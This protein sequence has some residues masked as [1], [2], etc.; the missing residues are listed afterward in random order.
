M[1]LGTSFLSHHMDI[2]GSTGD[3]TLPSY[4]LYEVDFESLSMEHELGQGA[5]G[6]VMKATLSCAPEGL[7][8]TRVPITVAAKM[9]K[10][11]PKVMQCCVAFKLDHRYLLQ[12]THSRANTGV[13]HFTC[14]EYFTSPGIEIRQ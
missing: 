1:Q 6:R 13:V 10:G 2:D 9:L 5:F 12:T 11:E 8:G 7:K 14:V 4:D 3:Q